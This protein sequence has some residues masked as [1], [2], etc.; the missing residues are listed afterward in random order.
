MD[1]DPAPTIFKHL[2]TQ[3][4]PH[5]NPE[6]LGSTYGEVEEKL[7]DFEEWLHQA[8]GRGFYETLV[9]NA[10][11]WALTKTFRT[12][13]ENRGN[14]LVCD[15]FSIRELL[16]L[17]HHF[18]ERLS[19]KVGRA[20]APTTTENVAKSF[21]QTTTLK[22]AFTTDRLIEGEMW[23]GE[24]INDLNKPP[25][26]GSETGH[27][28]LSQYPDSPLTHAVVHRTTQVQDLTIVIDQ[29]IEL[30]EHLTRNTPL[31]ITG[32]H[33]Y[34]YLGPNPQRNLWD[35]YIRAERYG[36][37]YG[38]KGMRVKDVNVAIGRFHAN[39]TSGSNTFITHGGVSLTESLVPVVTIDAGV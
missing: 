9:T 13:A 26:L 12:A 4:E 39:P 28:L 18:K 16:V 5:I 35:P 27:M 11:G 15:G 30:V 19:Y 36:G 2:L 37:N 25:R 10:E 38:E 7:R 29:I 22:E 1:S 14:V 17:R 24:I 6:D 32:D 33:G 20:P 3:L 34:I 21:F 23:R 8:W 31:T